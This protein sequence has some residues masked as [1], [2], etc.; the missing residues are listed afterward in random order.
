MGQDNLSNPFA[1]AA[2]MPEDHVSAFS[3]TVS[4]N[5]AKKMHP[6]LQS[7]GGM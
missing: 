5:S 4:N 6:R 3:D 1:N 2:T 7:S